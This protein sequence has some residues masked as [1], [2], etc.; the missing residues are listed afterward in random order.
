MGSVVLRRRA[1]PAEVWVG[2][3]PRSTSAAGG[4]RWCAP[5]RDWSETTMTVADAHHA[6]PTDIPLVDLAAST[7]RSPTRSRPASRA[8]MASTGFIGGAR[9]AGLRARLRPPGRAA[10]TAVGVANGTDAL[11]LVLRAAGIGAGDEVILPANTFIA[12]AEAVCPDRRPAGL[13]RRRPEPPADRSRAAG[14][15]GSPRAR[16]RRSPCTSTARWR[17]WSV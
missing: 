8:V 3:R 7:P 13:R 17:P 16:G 5:H 2:C 12:T 9:V 6:I 14:G 1:R 11:E 4:H 15:R 10:R